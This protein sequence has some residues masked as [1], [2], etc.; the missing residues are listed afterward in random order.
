MSDSRDI[1]KNGD[2]KDKE[3]SKDKKD[4]IEILPP[5]PPE[6]KELTKRKLS[7]VALHS[8]LPPEITLATLPHISSDERKMLIQEI[9]KENERMYQAFLETKK[10]KEKESNK[11]RIFTIFI[12]LILIS[13]MFALLYLGKDAY[14]EKLLQILLGAFG[15]GG[16]IIYKIYKRKVIDTDDE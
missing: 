7:G 14:F 9:S 4:D 15:G 2:S 16:L 5:D 10:Y 12:I 1:Q 11:D 13:V 6:L 8:N 3:K